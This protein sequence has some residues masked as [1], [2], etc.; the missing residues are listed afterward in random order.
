MSDKQFFDNDGQDYD[1][2]HAHN[3]FRAA[4]IP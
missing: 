3:P 4:S 2:I 1:G